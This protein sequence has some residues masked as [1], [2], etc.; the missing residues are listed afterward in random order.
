MVEAFG[1][2]PQALRDLSV[3]LEI[4]GDL[5]RVLTRSD[6]ALASYEESLGIRRSLLEA[7]GEAPQALLDLATVCGSL[8]ELR[9]AESRGT[10]DVLA[11]GTHAIE[12]AIQLYGKLPKLVE[13]QEW[14]KSLA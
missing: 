2:S 10:R 4:V 12:R 13:V 11:E 3:S 6:E 1:E 9:G 8:V 5:Q 14:L 7:F